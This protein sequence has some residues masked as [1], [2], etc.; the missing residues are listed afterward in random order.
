M[1]HIALVVLSLLLLT[2]LTWAQKTRYGQP[3]IPEPEK[4]LKIYVNGV[5]VKQQC[6]NN[7]SSISCHEVLFVEII[8]HTTKIELK[9]IDVNSKSFPLITLGYYQ[10]RLVENKSSTGH[11]AL[12]Q[13]YELQLPDK[14]TWKGEVKGYSGQDA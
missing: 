14:T 8:Y 3:S 9:G 7:A 6:Y 1:K 2:T 13:I 11:I 10:A 5:Q 12:G 4:L